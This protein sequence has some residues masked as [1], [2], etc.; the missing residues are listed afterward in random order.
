M[1]SP[2]LTHEDRALLNAFRR[3]LDKDLGDT[4]ES[5]TV[6]GSKARGE[7]TPDSDLDILVLVKAGDWRLKWRV[8]D[9]AYG[10]AVGT[11]VV[12]SV[13][14]YTRSEWDRLRDIESEFYDSVAQDGIAAA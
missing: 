12:P 10:L 6:F 13:K 3:W 5:V 7:A 2:N 9:I 4:V 11:N 8:A 14:V 1:P